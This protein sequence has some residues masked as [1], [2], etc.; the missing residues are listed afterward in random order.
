MKLI[1]TWQQ[2]KHGQLI[3]LNNGIKM[4]NGDSFLIPYIFVPF[5]RSHAEIRIISIQS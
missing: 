1:E 5:F 2:A 3:V 4:L